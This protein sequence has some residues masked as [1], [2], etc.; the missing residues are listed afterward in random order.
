M[1]M[2]SVRCMAY[3]YCTVYSVHCTVIIV[4]CVVYAVGTLRWPYMDI[5]IVVLIDI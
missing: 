2:A 3:I 1:V 4:V 5:G